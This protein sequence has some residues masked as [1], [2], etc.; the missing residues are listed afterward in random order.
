MIPLTGDWTGSGRD[1]VGFYNRRDGWFHLRASL[2]ADRPASLS[3][4]ARRI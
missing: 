1:G 2:D 3:S 4:S